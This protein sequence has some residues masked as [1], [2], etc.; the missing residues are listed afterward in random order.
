M[1]KT[2]ELLRRHLAESDPTKDP[3][4]HNMLLRLLAEEEAKGKRMRARQLELAERMNGPP[5]YVRFAR[6]GALGPF[7]EQV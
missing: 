3:Q 1:R 2:L 5:R 7:L 6:P 4:R